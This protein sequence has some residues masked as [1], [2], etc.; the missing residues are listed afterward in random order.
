MT[1]PTITIVTCTY[2]AA[3]TLRRTLDSVKG[4]TY[5]RVEHIIVDGM[6]GDGT[7]TI[8]QTYVDE[9]NSAATER[10]ARAIVEPDGGLYDAMNKG[11][12]AATGDYLLFLNAGDKLHASDTLAV[13]ADTIGQGSD[14]AVAYG[15]TDIVDAGGRFLCRRRL[16]PPKR[17]TWR[18]FRWGMLVCHQA[19]YVR[20]DIALTVAYDLRYRYSADVDW[21]IRV[22]K[23]AERRGQQM[24][25]TGAV[26]VDYLDEGLT[27]RHHRASLAERFAVMRRH[28]GLV[29]TVAMHGLFVLRSVLFVLRNIFSR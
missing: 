26:L 22:M 28:Y 24:L 29:V 7:T 27:T 1:K 6:S 8:A 14:T 10:H 19:F 13:V 16:T 11:I 18:S 4:Q 12:A 17:L 15:D 23:E 9:V 20:R 2:N 25:N 3:A 5:A 21:C